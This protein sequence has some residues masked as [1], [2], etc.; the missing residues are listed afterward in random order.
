MRKVLLLLLPL[1]VLLTATVFWSNGTSSLNLPFESQTTIAQLSF[2]P[3]NA[4]TLPQADESKQNTSNLLFGV[5]SDI[6][7]QD[8]NTAAQNKFQQML[9]DMVKLHVSDLVINGDLGDGTPQDYATLG[10]LIRRQ[11]NHPVIYYTIG[12]HEFYKA[13]HNPITNVW[14]PGTFPNGETETNAINRFLNFTKRSKVYYDEYLKGYHF[15]FLGSEK[16]AISNRSYGDRAY[17]SEQQLTWLELKI[18]ENYKLNKPV[19]IFLHQPLAQINKTQNRPDY[20]IQ[21]DR[22]RQILDQFPEVIFFSGHIHRKLE[23]PTT[24]L[25]E[26]FVMVNSS[27]VALPRDI[28]GRALPNQSEGLIVEVLQNKVFINGRDFMTKTWIPGTQ[29]EF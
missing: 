26:R 6:H 19:F 8:T 21:A 17:L 4:N 7:V 2:T 3:I 14:S 11:K 25:K 28:N 12:N 29:Y 13:Y 10:K 15:I 20:V 24:V 5:V 9:G 18:K 1:V 23:L 16:S 27:S 22:L